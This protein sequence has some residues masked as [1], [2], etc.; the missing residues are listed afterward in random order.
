MNCFQTNHFN[1]SVFPTIS[2]GLYVTAVLC[3]QSSLPVSFV[4]INYFRFSKTITAFFFS[5]YTGSPKE[6][7]IALELKFWQFFLLTS[8]LG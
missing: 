4:V 2:A 6:L 3:L 7:F 8:K 1:L 5:P